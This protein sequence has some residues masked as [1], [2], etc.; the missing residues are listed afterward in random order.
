M[1]CRATSLPPLS[2]NSDCLLRSTRGLT[3]CFFVALYLI[4]ILY[5]RSIAERDPGS[6]FFNRHTAY[7][8]LYSN[9]RRRQAESFVAATS[10]MGSFHRSSM[11]H[12]SLRLCV[13]VPSI[14]RDDVHYLPLT[15]GSLLAGLTSE[16]RDGIH[17]IIFIPHSNPAIHPAY[18]EP[19][20]ANNADEILQYNVTNQELG[21][22]MNMELEQEFFR[23]KGLYDYTYLMRACNA[24]GAPYIAMLEDDTIAMDGWYHRTIAGIEEAET[25]ST[26]S[27]RGRFGFMYLRLFYTETLLGWNIEEWRTYTIWSLGV[28]A[29]SWLA[30]SCSTSCSRRLRLYLTTEN[31]IVI[32]MV[33]IP[34]MITLFFIAGRVTMLPL[35]SGVNVMNNYGCC[36][37]G[38]VFPRQKA[39]DLIS[40]YE[41][42]GIGFADALTEEYADERNELRLALTPSVIQHIGVKSSKAGDVGVPPRSHASPAKL[43]NFEFELFKEAELQAEHR[44]FAM[45]R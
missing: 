44:K 15:I 42:K 9:V 19:W 29:G 41:Q 30:L 33:Q 11:G 40:W 21:H 26:R 14:A 28:I 31:M 1:K 18:H 43:W 27:N 16:E 39:Q 4:L 25:I 38:L 5:V 17:L 6:W 22:I 20:L 35:P 3:A 36:S 13:G 12:D 32:C 37:Q 23:E 7:D 45:E 34:L 2:S 8:A 10:A 24:T